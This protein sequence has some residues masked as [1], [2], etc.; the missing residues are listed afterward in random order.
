MMWV[1]NRIVTPS[2]RSS[3]TAS[4]MT[5]VLTGS[6]PAN[7]SS[8]TTSSG[9]CR[10]VEMNCTF[11]CM[12]FDSSSTRRQ[13]HAPRPSR[14]S[15][16]AAWAPARRRSTPFISARNTIRS[17]TR[18]LRYSPRSS[19]RYPTR[20]EVAE[21][22]VLGGGVVALHHGAHPPGER[23]RLRHRLLLEQVCHHR[24]GGLTDGAAPAHEAHVPDHGVLDQEL[25]LDL[26][27]AQ[28]VVERHGVGGVLERPLVAG[29][30]VVVEDQ[31][32]IERAE[33]GLRR[34][35]IQT[36]LRP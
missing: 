35:R 19:G 2:R 9:W 31:L 33:L 6:S 8:S 23:E 34:G 4:F 10:M 15:Q 16:A 26:V 17:S 18:I 29:A 21:R 30:P 28:R 32:L 24:R 14:S 36:A 5:C 13:R 25:E 12:P 27:A 20:P 22:L 3:R 1:E 7:G 11:C